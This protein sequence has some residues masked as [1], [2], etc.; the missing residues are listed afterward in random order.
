VTGHLT[1]AT[2]IVTIIEDL[3]KHI[4]PKDFF[5]FA[6][7]KEQN[8]LIVLDC[9]MSNFLST[10]CYSDWTLNR[11]DSYSNHYNLIKHIFQKTLFLLLEKS[12]II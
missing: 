1:E 9:N 5:V 11:G 8:H 2:P 7:G 12:K 4:F 3:M 10:A 6:A